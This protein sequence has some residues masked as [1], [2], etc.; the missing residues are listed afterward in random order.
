MIVQLNA[1]GGKFSLKIFQ[2]NA[3]VGANLFMERG[4][5]ASQSYD[6]AG[7]NIADQ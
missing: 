4:K 1:A 5:R 2:N 3:N 6:W 7:M